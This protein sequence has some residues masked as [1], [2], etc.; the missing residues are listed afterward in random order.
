MTAAHLSQP[1]PYLLPL[2]AGAMELRAVIRYKKKFIMYTDRNVGYCM[3]TFVIRNGLGILRRN[4]QAYITYAQNMAKRWQINAE[5]RARFMAFARGWADFCNADNVLARIQNDSYLEFAEQYVE[6]VLT[7]QVSTPAPT[8]NRFCGVLLLLNPPPG[9]PVHLARELRLQRELR[10]LKDC[11]LD[12]AEGGSW[13]TLPL[14]RVETVRR[15]LHAVGRS[16]YLLVWPEI[17]GHKSKFQAYNNEF[18]RCILRAFP[19]MLSES[20]ESYKSRIDSVLAD[21][22]VQ[23]PLPN[24]KNHNGIELQAKKLAADLG[25]GVRGSPSPDRAV[26]VLFA[27]M[28]GL[29]KSTLLRTLFDAKRSKPDNWD[30]YLYSGDILDKQF[31]SVMLDPEGQTFFGNRR[32]RIV[33]GDRNMVPSPASHYRTTAERMR[34]AGMAP[35][36]VLPRSSGDLNG[37]HGRSHPLSLPLVALSMIRVMNRREHEGKRQLKASDPH[38][39]QVVAMFAGFYRSIPPAAFIEDV[40]V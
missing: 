19:Q 37:V 26:G 24:P 8:Y 36:I 3:M 2:Q 32:T 5:Q 11:S 9:M 16:A 18:R 40:Q 28:P 7:Q 30:P 39:C 38:I 15:E 35:C 33:F 20:Q 4:T 29:G 34:Q 25:T 14:K 10:S 17:E 27:G 1:H 21:R 31:W 6:Q 13:Y 22:I 12:A 23:R